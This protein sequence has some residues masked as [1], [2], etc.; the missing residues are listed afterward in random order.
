MKKEN[1]SNNTSFTGHDFIRL[2]SPCLLFILCSCSD[3][4]G[5]PYPCPRVDL[6]PHSVRVGEISWVIG[7]QSGEF[8]FDESPEDGDECW[9]EAGT[10]H[11]TEDVEQDYH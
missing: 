2:F 5:E 8:L 7:D 11:I 1:H 9:A 4:V 10:G 6:M 3:C